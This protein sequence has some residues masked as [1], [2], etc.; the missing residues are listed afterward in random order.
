M[1]IPRPIGDELAAERPNAQQHERDHRGNGC[2]DQDIQAV[3]GEPGRSLVEELAALV[4]EILGSVGG[5]AVG[6]VGHKMFRPFIRP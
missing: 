1:S 4:R 6:N 2:R 5:G 3:A